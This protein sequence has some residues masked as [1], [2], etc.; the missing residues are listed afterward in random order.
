M[1]KGALGYRSCLVYK[2]LNTTRD[3]NDKP[4][5]GKRVV[6]TALDLEQKEHR[7]IATYSK[8]VI[9]NLKEAGA[10]VWLLTQFDVSKKKSGLNRLPM[11]T[12]EII[13][14]SK[15]LGSLTTGLEHS[16]TK[17]IEKRFAIANKINR[18][19]K[20][21]IE[22]IDL[23]RRP[24]FYNSR[25]IN[26]INLNK[27][28]DNPNLRQERLSYLQNVE[29]LLC[30]RKI[31]HASQT[32]ALLNSPRPVTIDLKGFDA[33]ITS[34][35]LNIKPINI[36]KFIQSI[37]DVIA[38]EYAPHNENMLQFSHRLQACLNSRRVYVSE[39]TAIKYKNNIQEDKYLKRQN[40]KNCRL[41]KIEKTIIQPPSLEFPN[42][43][44]SN[45]KIQN[46]MRPVSY[47]LSGE[48][49]GKLKPYQYLLFNSSVEARKNLLFLVK[50]YAESNLGQEGIKLCVTGK[51][52]KDPFSKAVKE[53]VK[54]EPGIILTGYIDESTKLDLYLNAITLVSPSLVEGFG[55]PALDAACLGM[56]AI[57]SSCDAHHEIK[58]IDDFKDYI[59]PINTLN[60]REWAA[61][62]QSISFLHAAN[63]EAPEIERGR[64][65]Q[66]Y[67]KKSSLLNK[68]FREDLI[69]LIEK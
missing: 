63:K 69:D 25:Q 27:L 53:V 5:K 20:L 55:I 9:R 47:L 31:F 2:Q 57:V 44:A 17:W 10:E 34:C 23:I 16:D 62:I 19:W 49:K 38:L 13:H 11:P 12:Q 35:P 15:V 61:A 40:G 7:G 52:K 41:E 56:P 24:R 43:L 18:L 8:A 29:G 14:S 64:R 59:I 1:L 58:L 36:S 45:P 32:A 21:L 67:I 48:G 22:V 50:A 6:F 39:S 37:H 51:L 42:W 3:K 4:L 65:I 30:A 66:R 68:K 26:H 54:Q 33:F 28:F 60:T 46:D